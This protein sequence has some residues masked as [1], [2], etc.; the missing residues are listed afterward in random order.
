MTDPFR[1]LR[2]IL[3]REKIEASSALSHPKDCPCDLCKRVK[4]W[5]EKE[6]TAYMDKLEREKYAEEAEI[7]AGLVRYEVGANDTDG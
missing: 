4:A 2:H 6:A 1:I 7:R 3:R 5:Q